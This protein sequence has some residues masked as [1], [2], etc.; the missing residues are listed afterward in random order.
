MV[1]I[2]DGLRPSWGP[3]APGVACLLP[4]GHHHSWTADALATGAFRCWTSEHISLLFLKSVFMG[5][6]TAGWRLCPH[7]TP[8]PGFERCPSIAC[9][10]AFFQQRNLLSF[11]FLCFYNVTFSSQ[12]LL[13]H[14]RASAKQLGFL[15]LGELFMRFVFGVRE[16]SW[17]CGLIVFINCGKFE[18]VI[19]QMFSAFSLHCCLDTV[20]AD[21]GTT[22]EVSSL[23]ASV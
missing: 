6:S 4:E 17:V 3:F 16:P 19:F 11:L 8:P 15:G 13:R 21:T 22:V 1:P 7:T 14:L 5:C 10:L 9:W 18:A 23:M 20:Q 2:S 12:L